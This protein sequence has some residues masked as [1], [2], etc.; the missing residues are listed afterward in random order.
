M[1]PP[2]QTRVIQ[3][4]AKNPFPQVLCAHP[5]LR[6]NTARAL[7]ASSVNTSTR[8][9][10]MHHTIAGASH[11]KRLSDITNAAYVCHTVP[12]ITPG[13]PTRT[14]RNPKPQTLNAQPQTLNP[15]PSTRNPK[16]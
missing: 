8:A 3:V 13:S 6:K 1:P 12:A 11:Q 14:Q 4:D 2:P 10:N 16:P 15:K 9:Q 5:A 7:H